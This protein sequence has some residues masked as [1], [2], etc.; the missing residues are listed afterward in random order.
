MAP[1]LYPATRTAYV[2]E[3]LSEGI[4]AGS[5]LRLGIGQASLQ[6]AILSA[7]GRPLLLEEQRPANGAA[8]PELLRSHRLGL[9]TAGW[10][11]VEG[12]ICTEVFTLVPAP[13][14]DDAQA[15]RY[16][17]AT[18]RPA[19]GLSFG[20]VYT[21]GDS[22]YGLVNV[23]APQLPWL[24]D[25]VDMLPRMQLRHIADVMLAFAARE[26]G[27][28]GL[29]QLLVQDGVLFAAALRD[30]ALQ[31]ACGYPFATDDE[32][33]YACRQAAHTTAMLAGVDRIMLAG[34]VPAGSERHRRIEQALGA[35]A[36]VSLATH[37]PAYVEA[38]PWVGVLH[39]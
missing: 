7:E 34:Q 18:A 36:F 19:D 35:V 9:L 15:V 32:L 22:T 37:L 29:L 30:S 38:W 13:F 23:Y 11:A 10:A 17:A 27:T 25:M 8:M 1:M 12:T 5:R 16:L 4:A 14:F 28:E 3:S 21:S 2:D 39:D 6:L 20:K 33:I 26:T 31:L 24:A